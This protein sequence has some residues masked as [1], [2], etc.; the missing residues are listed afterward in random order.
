MTNENDEQH[1]TPASGA[2][3]AADIASGIRQA[4]ASFGA[5]YQTRRAQNTAVTQN[6][7][8]EVVG[9]LQEALLPALASYVERMEASAARIEAAAQRIENATRGVVKEVQE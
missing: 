2:R 1:N 7:A 4:Q 9:A 6:V 5:G 8:D 3:T